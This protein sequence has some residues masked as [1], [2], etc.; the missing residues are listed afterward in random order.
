M[1][2]GE[3]AALGKKLRALGRSWWEGTQALAPGE[4]ALGQDTKGE[5]EAT[6]G[7][8]GQGSEEGLNSVFGPGSLAAGR[9]SQRGRSRRRERSCGHPA[10]GRGAASGRRAAGQGSPARGSS[11]RGRAVPEPPAPCGVPHGPALRGC[12]REEPGRDGSPGRCCACWK[13][14]CSS[15]PCSPD[16]SRRSP[17]IRRGEMRGAWGLSPHQRGWGLRGEGR[18]QRQARG[19]RR[20][21]GPPGGDRGR[22]AGA[23][24]PTAA[25]PAPCSAW[26]PPPQVCARARRGKLERLL[27][28]SSATGRAPRL[29]H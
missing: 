21:G 3:L 12:A 4:G 14:S 2:Q 10:Q 13:P 8:K 20:G 27:P 24:R 9:R 15:L 17:G 23:A 16:P 28:V 22:S 29:C 5:G 18:A 25:E 6:S 11:G 19:S 1:L 26:R 7:G